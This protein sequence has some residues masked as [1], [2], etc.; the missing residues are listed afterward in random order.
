MKNHKAKHFERLAREI[1]LA[2]NLLVK[3]WCNA[4]L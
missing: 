1:Y 3:K 2:V 4:G